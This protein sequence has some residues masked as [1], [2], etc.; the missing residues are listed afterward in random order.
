VKDTE[1][2]RMIQDMYEGIM[3]NFVRCLTCGYE[4]TNE[5]KFRDLSLYVKNEF[6]N[7][8]NDSLE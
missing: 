2:E 8:Y 4:S 5:E 3:V 7:V 6:E 1:N